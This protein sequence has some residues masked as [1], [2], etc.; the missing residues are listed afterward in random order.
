[1]IDT[2]GMPL[3]VKAGKPWDYCIGGL[4][5]KRTAMRGSGLGKWK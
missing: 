1:L 4:A 2:K 3:S 5:L